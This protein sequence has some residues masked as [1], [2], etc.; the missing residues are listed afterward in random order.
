MTTNESYYPLNNKFPVGY[1]IAF[2]RKYKGGIPL[3]TMYYFS[4]EILMVQYYEWSDLD[5]KCLQNLTV[6][7]FEKKYLEIKDRIVKEL[8]EPIDIKQEDRRIE[9]IWDNSEKHIE[10][11]LYLYGNLRIRLIDY[12]KNQ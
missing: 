5:C 8:G 2:I 11:H 4:N 6:H 9:I 12:W 1:P 3:E 7:D 10:L